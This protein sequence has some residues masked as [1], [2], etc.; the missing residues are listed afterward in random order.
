MSIRKPQVISGGGGVRTSCT[1][2]LD[3]PLN[4][5][6]PLRVYDADVSVTIRNYKYTSV[7][8][9]LHAINSLPKVD[10]SG[11]RLEKDHLP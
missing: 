9:K 10:V 7:T 11:P 1:L 3:P 8:Q 2:P 6:A 4:Y 5:T